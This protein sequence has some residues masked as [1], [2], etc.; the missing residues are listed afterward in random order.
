MAT[1]TAF[2]KFRAPKYEAYFQPNA[3]I[4]PSGQQGVYNVTFEEELTGGCVADIQFDGDFDSDDD[5]NGHG[6]TAV[7]QMQDLNGNVF[8]HDSQEGDT[9]QWGGQ[10]KWK[11]RRH[12]YIWMP[13]KAE[14]LAG[15]YLFTFYAFGQE[16]PE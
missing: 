8:N 5:S 6:Y 4:G 13:T 16:E 3:A 11:G 10:I 1:K 12:C 7:C 9:T 15:D 2:C 14:C